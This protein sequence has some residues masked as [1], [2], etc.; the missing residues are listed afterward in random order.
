[1]Q[2]PFSPAAGAGQFV[3]NGCHPDSESRAALFPNGTVKVTAR[4]IQITCSKNN[5]STIT[6]TNPSPPEG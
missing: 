4:A 3:E 1:M 2:M 6:S 5:T